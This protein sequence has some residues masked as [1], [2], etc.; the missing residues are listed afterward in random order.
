MDKTLLLDPVRILR[1][2]GQSVEQGAVLV[3]EGHPYGV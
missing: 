1:G 3:E 2:I